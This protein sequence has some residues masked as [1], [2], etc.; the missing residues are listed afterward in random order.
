MT[1]EGRLGINVK[2]VFK[3][4]DQT[5]SL[6]PHSY[7]VKSEYCV[8]CISQA[9]CILI[10]IYFCNFICHILSVVLESRIP[11]LSNVS[12]FSVPQSLSFVMFLVM[13][14]PQGNTHS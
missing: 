10:P 9:L 4:P 7:R 2:T 6:A 8:L 11:H 12:P 3:C 13:V 14:R 5:A 1:S